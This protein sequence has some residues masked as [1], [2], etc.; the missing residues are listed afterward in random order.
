MNRVYRALCHLYTV[1]CPA[2]RRCSPSHIVLFNIFLP[3]FLARFGVSG[4]KVCLERLKD[5]VEIPCGHVMCLTCLSA[6]FDN[7]RS[8]PLCKQPIPADF[9]LVSTPEIK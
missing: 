7:V 3:F 6:W 1:S 8:C 9:M 4:C 5:P 2:P